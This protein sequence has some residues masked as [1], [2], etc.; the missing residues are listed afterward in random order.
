MSQLWDGTQ[1]IG[2]NTI[3]GN[4]NVVHKTYKKAGVR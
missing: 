2:N 4:G 3:D 1:P